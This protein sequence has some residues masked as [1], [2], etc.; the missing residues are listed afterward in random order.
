MQY[1]CLCSF[2]TYQRSA[3]IC[4]VLAGRIL[5]KF[6]IVLPVNVR[7]MA[8]SLPKTIDVIPF[9]TTTSTKIKLLCTPA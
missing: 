7:V 4:V 1:P 8:H 9:R 3:S 5:N 6:L 2:Q